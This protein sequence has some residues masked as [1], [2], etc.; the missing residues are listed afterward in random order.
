VIVSPRISVNTNGDRIIKDE[1]DI[2]YYIMHPIFR[3]ATQ[4]QQEMVIGL[5]IEGW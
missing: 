4:P 3:T 5:P 1:A 2:G